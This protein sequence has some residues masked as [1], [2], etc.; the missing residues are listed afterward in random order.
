MTRNFY[1]GYTPNPDA[2][3]FGYIPPFN[4]LHFTI[5]FTN[6]E[7]RTSR[8]GDIHVRLENHV[9]STHYTSIEEG[10]TGLIIEVAQPFLDTIAPGAIITSVWNEGTED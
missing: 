7:S 10:W 1:H 9:I 8:Q 6:C 4:G 3:P 2:T 5:D